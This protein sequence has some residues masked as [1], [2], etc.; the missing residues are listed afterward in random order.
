MS[1]VL[2]ASQAVFVVFAFRRLIH[3][4]LADGLQVA[5]SLFSLGLQVVVNIR[6]QQTRSFVCILNCGQFDFE[7]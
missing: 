3:F 1:L 6:L 2:L 7:R 5:L 4:S